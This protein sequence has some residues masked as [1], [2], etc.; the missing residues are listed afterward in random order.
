MKNGINLFLFHHE[1]A[2]R[3]RKEEKEEAVTEKEE[4]ED[5]DEEEEE[6]EDEEKKEKSQCHSVNSSLNKPVQLLWKFTLILNS[7]QFI[8]F[9][10][11]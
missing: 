6:E 5:E 4:K 1:G 3:W 7:L 10:N 9:D 11:H 2:C 8:I